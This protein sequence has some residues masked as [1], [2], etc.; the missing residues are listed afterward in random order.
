MTDKKDMETITH[1][2]IKINKPGTGMNNKAD[3]DFYGTI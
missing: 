2:L 1:E 3:K